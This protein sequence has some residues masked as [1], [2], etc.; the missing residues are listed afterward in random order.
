[1]VEVLFLWALGVLVILIG[2]K[3]MIDY[4][5]R[6]YTAP[7][8]P[9]VPGTI[10]VAC[11]GDSITYGVLI[12]RRSKNCYPAQLQNLLG[13]RYSVRNFGVNERTMQK[14]ADLPYWEHRNFLLSTEFNPD[15]V[16]IMLGTNDSKEHN[17]INIE[18]YIHDYREMLVHYR[19]LP[20]NPVVYVMTPPR[21]FLVRGKTVVY[22]KMSNE[23]IDTMARAIKILAEEENI[24]VIDINAATTSHPECFWLDGV[25]PNAAGARIIAETVYEEI[26]GNENLL[27]KDHYLS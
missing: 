11:V 5:V 13:E 25:H 3:Y 24:K 18:A 4:F 16:L 19:S 10:R 14:S 26:L 7:I 17:W 21:M 22:Y 2:G 6:N 20:S 27:R 1:M 23:V 9:A 8:P 12:W 15:I